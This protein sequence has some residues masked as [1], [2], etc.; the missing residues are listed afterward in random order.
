MRGLYSEGCRMQRR[1][2]GREGIVIGVQGRV[3]GL[4]DQDSECTVPASGCRVS[5]HGQGIR[6]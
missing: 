5:V 3:K 1:V 6:V 2:T 4:R